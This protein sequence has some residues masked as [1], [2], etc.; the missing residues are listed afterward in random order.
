MVSFLCLSIN[1]TNDWKPW[2]AWPKAH[3]DQQPSEVAVEIPRPP[4]RQASYVATVKHDL[5]QAMNVSFCGGGPKH[6]PTCYITGVSW[7]LCLKP[8]AGRTC[9]F[10]IHMSSTRSFGPLLP[11]WKLTWILKFTPFEKRNHL[12]NLHFWGS[13]CVFRSVAI[14]LFFL[15]DLCCL[16]LAR[17]SILKSRKP[18]KLILRTVNVSCRFRLTPFKQVHISQ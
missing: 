8:S 1:Q 3:G 16:L 7:P 10:E 9:D 14:Q 17:C 11:P 18:S 4:K 5:F 2:I 15:A 12:P 6:V 13:M